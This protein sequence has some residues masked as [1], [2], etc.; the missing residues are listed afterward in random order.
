M[1]D[2]ILIDTSAW[3]DFFRKKDLGIYRL[4]AK[5]LKEKR[6]VGSGIIALELI[7]GGKTI[8][9]LNYLN[10][11]FEVIDTVDPNP[12]SYFLAGKLGYALA[13]KGHTVSIVDLLIAQLA[14]ENNLALLTLD[15][16]FQII[17]KY[18]SLRLQEEE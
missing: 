11:L 10:D 17:K 3:I 18:S 7:R 15:K 13:R 14:I 2:K 16:H 4:V 6:A 12:Q 5:L 1:E 8:K 9:E